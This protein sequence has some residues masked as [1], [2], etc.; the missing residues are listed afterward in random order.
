MAKPDYAMWDRFDEFSLTEAASL[1]CDIEPENWV[2]LHSSPQYNPMPPAIG[3]MAKTLNAEPWKKVL[4]KQILITRE[5]YDGWLNISHPARYREEV[6]I[7][8]PRAALRAWAERTGR[9]ADMPFLL[10]PEERQ[11][12]PKPGPAALRADASANLNALVGLLTLALVKRGGP[13][14]RQTIQGREG[15]NLSAVAKELQELANEKGIDTTGLS[16]KSLTDRLNAGQ[17]E[18]EERR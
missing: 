11:A 4:R 12:P 8:F 13:G 1:C 2:G 14:F 16:F 5:S 6:T 18:L 10:N 3:A 17:A 7:T 15:P 9:L